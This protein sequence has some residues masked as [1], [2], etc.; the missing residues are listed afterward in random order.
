MADIVQK[1]HDLGYAV[2]FYDY[3]GYGTSQGQPSEAHLYLDIDAAYAYL[4]ETLKVPPARIIIYGRSLGGAPSIDLATRKPVAGLVLQSTFTTAFRVVTQIP[5]LP[6]DKFHSIDKIVRVRCPVL[7]IH[8][9][10]DQV[11]PFHHGVELYH[12]VRAPKR[13][14]WVAGADHNDL[15]EVA[16]D[17]YIAALDDFTTLLNSRP[18]LPGKPRLNSR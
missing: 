6:F 8:G 7:V 10:A 14:C 9:R 12:A 4:T 11:I 16:G 18:P 15:V 17:Q 2:L 3:H 5:L 13:C 1:L